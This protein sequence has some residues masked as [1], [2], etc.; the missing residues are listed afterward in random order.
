[1]LPVPA[2]DVHASVPYLVLSARGN[3][4]F[5]DDTHKNIALRHRDSDGVEESDNLARSY[6]DR[7]MIIASVPLD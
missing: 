6:R 7:L 1:M 3:F 2:R 4:S 5:V